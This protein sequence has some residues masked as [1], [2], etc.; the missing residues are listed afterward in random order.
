MNSTVNADRRRRELTEVSNGLVRKGRNTERADMKRKTADLQT[1]T[2]ERDDA[3]A[4]LEQRTQELEAIT[5]ERD[6]LENR[7]IDVETTLTQL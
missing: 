2:T 6:N 3:R 1:R 7:L 5:T 4:L